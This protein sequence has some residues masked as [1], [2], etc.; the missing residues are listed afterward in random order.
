MLSVERQSGP[1]II[2]VNANCGDCSAWLPRTA[3]A[4][5]AIFGRFEHELSLILLGFR[6]SDMKHGPASEGNAL[7]S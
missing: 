7:S 4:I 5:A 2:V 1:V 6:I 3:S